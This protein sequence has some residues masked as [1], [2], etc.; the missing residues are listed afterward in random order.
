MAVPVQ[1]DIVME[2]VQKM[3]ISH[4]IVLVDYLRHKVIQLEKSTESGIFVSD[5]NFVKEIYYWRRN[6][7]IFVEEVEFSKRGLSSGKSDRSTQSTVEAG[8][9]YILQSL[10]SLRDRME[11]VAQS[12]VGLLAIIEAEKSFDEARNVTRLTKL[13]MLFVPLSLI[14]GIFSMSSDYLPGARHF[15]IYFAC[16]IPLILLIFWPRRS[17]ICGFI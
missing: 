16:A 11:G 7:I 9:N 4:W 6:C 5:V 13:G 10:Q 1:S 17:E 2:I 12:S 8:W 14:A 15:W 3:A